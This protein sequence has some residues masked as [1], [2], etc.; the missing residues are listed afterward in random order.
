[1]EAQHTLVVGEH[2]V[3]GLEYKNTLTLMSGYK[4]LRPPLTASN[5]VDTSKRCVDIIIIIIQTVLQLC[6][7]QHLYSRLSALRTMM[8]ACVLPRV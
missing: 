6:K 2:L 1:M 5:N 3:L 4:M 8:T 7:Q